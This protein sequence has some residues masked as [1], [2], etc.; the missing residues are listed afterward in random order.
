L[1]AADPDFHRRDLFEAISAGEFPEWEF[2][3][4]LFTEE[5]AD[6]ISRSIIS[7]RPS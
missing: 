5:E 3:V 4:Q 1:P 7:T 2:A 6:R